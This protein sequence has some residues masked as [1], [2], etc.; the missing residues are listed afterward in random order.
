VVKSSG[1]IYFLMLCLLVV[2]GPMPCAALEK[3][4]VIVLA[5]NNLK[6][7]IGLADYYMKKR[8]ISKEQLIVLETV[9]TESCSRAEYKKNIAEPVFAYLKKRNLAPNATCLVLM[10][11]MPLKI[12]NPQPEE[13]RIQKNL[14]RH[15]DICAAVDSEM[16]VIYEADY[17]LSGWID[18]PLFSGSKIKSPFVDGE[19]IFMICR[20]D[21]PAPE[22]VRRMIDDSV[23]TE[24]K[25]LHGNA[26]FDAR[27]P[28]ESPDRMNVYEQFDTYIHLAARRTIEKGVLPCKID[29]TRFLFQKG[30]C[31]NTAL[32]CG[33]YSLAEYVDAFEWA[34][35]AVAY[36]VASA[37]C[38]TLKNKNS[39]AWCKVM[40]EK[41]VAATLGPVDEPFLQA[42]PR[43]D[44]F[45]GFLF[46]GHSLVESY[47]RSTPYLSWKMV[48]I[49]DP[50]YQPFKNCRPDGRQHKKKD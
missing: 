16:A 12:S 50:M 14:Q 2:S 28:E 41:G 31:P 3:E 6:E 26:F 10:Y 42:F 8:G 1:K 30:D 32:Y 13:G 21:A 25:G 36:H 11:G 34:K 4:N 44:I 27:W 46:D 49:G 9:T 47:M 37:E 33:W 48:L 19:N 38:V 45:F 35:G 20:L 39:R 18:N 24:K 43:P 7:S 15:Y 17:P 5:N 29:T 22:M 40:L 23:E